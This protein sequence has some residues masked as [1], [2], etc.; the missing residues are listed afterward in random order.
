MSE[1]VIARPLHRH[2][3]NLCEG[4][5]AELQRM[6]SQSGIRASEV[7]RALVE[8]HLKKLKLKIPEETVVTADELES[9]ELPND[10]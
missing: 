3:I 9:T 8:R 7:I 2:S 1:R 10:G 6:Y 5:Y 4:D